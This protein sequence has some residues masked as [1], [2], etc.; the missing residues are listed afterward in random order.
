MS[1][2][3]RPLRIAIVSPDS[4]VLHEL[5][6][7]LSAV[8]YTVVTSKVIDESAAWRQ[9]SDSDFVLFDGRS[10]SNPTSITLSQRSDHPVYRIFL[11][12]PAASIDLSAWFAAGANDALRIPIS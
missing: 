6:W 12:D 2:S 5:S 1:H 3:A 9:F 4:G 10:I 8:G 11:Y 7:L